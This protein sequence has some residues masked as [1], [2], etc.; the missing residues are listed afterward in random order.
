MLPDLSSM[1]ESEPAPSDDA[2]LDAPTPVGDMPTQGGGDPASTASTSSS[3]LDRLCNDLLDGVAGP[4][5]LLHYVLLHRLGRGGT[6]VVYAAY[7]EKLDRKVAVKL[8]RQGRGQG[9]GRLVREAKAMARLADPNVAQVYEIGEAEGLTFIVMEFVDGI[10]LKRWLAQAPRSR[11]E[12]LAVFQA[13]GSGLR[14]AHAKGLVHRDFKPDNVMLRDDGRVLVLDFGIA[15]IDDAGPP[16]ELGDGSKIES[17]S[18]TTSTLARARLPT[19]PVLRAVTGTPAYMAPEQFLGRDTDARTDQWSFCVALWEA[20]HGQRPFAGGTV[21]ELCLAVTQ[22]VRTTPEHGDVPAW[23]RKVLERGLSVEPDRRWPSMAAL[24]Q[25]LDEDPTRRRRW[26]A[27]AVGVGTLV[28]GGLGG[29]YAW[30]EHR[31]AEALA[32]CEAEGKAI[33]ADWSDETR[34]ALERAFLATEL[35]FASS[36]WEHTARWMGEHAHDWSEVYTTAC[37]EARVEGR[38][39]EDAHASVT[40]CLDQRRASFSALAEAWAELDDQM[41]MRA[42]TAAASLTPASSCTSDPWVARR[43]RPPADA[44]AEVAALRTRLERVM[45]VRLAGRYDDAL[46]E[47]ETVAARAD[48]LAWRPIQ[49]EAQ[50]GLGRAHDALGKYEQASNAM[51]RA[52]LEALGGGDDM[53]ALDAATELTEIVGYRLARHAEGLRWGERA[54]MLIERLELHGTIHEAYLLDAVG[55]VQWKQG[56]YDDALTTLERALAI[57]DEVL[58]ARHLDLAGSLD[59]LGGLHLDRGDYDAALASHERALG[60]VQEILGPEH[61]N[62]AGSLNN[63]GTVRSKQGA[64]AEALEL[65]ERSLAI[66]EAALGP[67]HPLVAS[68]LVNL[69][70][71]LEHHGAYDRAVAALERALRIWEVSL[72]P[73]HPN[74]GTVLINLTS[75]YTRRGEHE[76]ALVAGRRALAIFE[77]S[78]GPEHPQVAWLLAAIGN[79]DLDRNRYG[80]AAETFQRGLEISE[81]ALGPDHPQVGSFLILEGS[82]LRGQGRHEPAFERFERALRLQEAAL[83]PDHVDVAIPLEEIGKLRLEQ[84]RHAEARAAFERALSIRERGA[85]PVRQIAQLRFEL[86]QVLWATGEQ[87]RGRQLAVAARDALRTLPEDG[88]KKLAEVEAWLRERPEP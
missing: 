36:A 15:R 71:E 23:L 72:G 55:K 13:A 77:A 73:E 83:G 30:R 5:R 19:D 1:R 48:A 66:K 37:V 39:S 8:W 47:A 7:D 51:W 17:L 59:A 70:G 60:I 69:G 75:V 4:T 65:H 52:S 54:A 76:R 79:V 82:A 3:R 56:A 41:L 18:G 42:T 2:T 9:Q 63:M 10:T 34:E 85:A 22:G 21:A 78:L 58:G 50:L 26:I 28:L 38:M 74:V 29:A 61:P 31:R 32:A 81:R 80:A 46:A 84:G 87:Q 11:R 64:R 33:D 67:E 49:A 43:M 44:K 24:L 6:G 14:G 12:I 40:D 62:I 45:A 88:A 25:A 16:V 57:K 20:L 27:A 68:S 35:P 86:G 53:A